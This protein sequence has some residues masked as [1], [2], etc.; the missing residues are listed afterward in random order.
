MT[1]K[2][3]FVF[4]IVLIMLSSLAA[5]ATVTDTVEVSYADNCNNCENTPFGYRIVAKADSY[6]DDVRINSDSDVNRIDVYWTAN[7]SLYFTVTNSSFSDGQAGGTIHI[8]RPQEDRKLV[9]G[10]YYDIVSWKGS[11]VVYYMAYTGNGAGSCSSFPHTRTNINV[12]RQ[13]RGPSMGA[14]NCGN[15]DSFTTTTVPVVV[16]ATGN[17]STIN[18]ATAYETRANKY[19]LQLGY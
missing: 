15:I 10:A 11:G 13:V 5:A 8:T 3:I 4:G 7:G 19:Q 16:A 17:V 1:G 18:N 12:T 14:D 2:K 9:N 6:L